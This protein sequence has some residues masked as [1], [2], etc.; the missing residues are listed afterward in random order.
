MENFRGYHDQGVRWFV[1]SLALLLVGCEYR[2]A[3]E[4]LSSAQQ[5]EDGSGEGV[6]STGGEGGTTGTMTGDGPGTATGTTTDEAT[7]ADGTTYGMTT[8]GTTTDGMTTAG[9]T[10]DATTTD[11]TT[12]DGTTTG[13]ELCGN[14]VVDVGEECDGDGWGDQCVDCELQWFYVFASSV[15]YQGNLGGVAGADE[16]CQKLAEAAKLKGTYLAWIADGTKKSS[17]ALRFGF[18]PEDTREFKLVSG[19][20]I[21]SNWAALLANSPVIPIDVTEKKEPLDVTTGFRNAWSGISSNGVAIE[22]AKTCSFWTASKHNGRVG[23]IWRETTYGGT[24][25]T[26]GA[27]WSD[28]YDFQCSFLAR[29]YCFQVAPAGG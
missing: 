3:R 22:G 25:C 9:T 8:A 24:D 21:A 6:S 16:K 27:E 7:G 1:S 10:T 15:A 18:K 28:C 11:G 14:G 17:P 4:S 5:E 19:D 20:T 12:T 2:Y 29:L 13:E 23:R 26:D